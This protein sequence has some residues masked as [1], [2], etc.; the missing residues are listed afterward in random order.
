MNGLRLL[1]AAAGS[2]GH[3]YPGLAVSS[4]VREEGRAEVLFVGTPRGFESRIVPA[5]GFEVEL[6]RVPRLRGRSFPVLARAA[7]DLLPSLQRMRR[8]IRRFRPDV[9]F[10]TGGSVSGMAALAARLTGVASLIFEPNADPGLATRLSAP[11]ATRLAVGW[12]A[13]ATGRFPGALV[14]GIPVRQRFLELAP[15]PAAA[16]GEVSVLVTGGSQGAERLNRLVTAALPELARRRETRIRVTHQTGP[17]D[18][19]R[20]RSAYERARIPAEVTAFLEDMPTAMERADLVVGRAGAITCAEIAAAGRP[21]VLVPALVAGAHQTK[22]AAAFADAGAAVVLEETALPARFAEAL[23][24]LAGDR[25]RR[26]RME[27]A[28]AALVQESPAARLAAEL[29]RLAGEGAR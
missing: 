20:V 15:P 3:I 2:G 8:L 13:T 5:H 21:A 12:E 19:A 17:A 4:A 25:P 24:G 7:L 22:N 1:V 23:A 28:A 6:I 26:A 10:G 14:S 27:Q 29:R 16:G 9:V 18:E 11:F